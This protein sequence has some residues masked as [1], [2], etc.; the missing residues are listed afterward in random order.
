MT[1]DV[2]SLTQLCKV[3]KG[4]KK[5][6]YLYMPFNIK[7]IRNLRGE[8]ITDLGYDADKSEFKEDAEE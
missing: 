1:R 7:A 5:I 8:D 6:I 2:G 4:V 3:L